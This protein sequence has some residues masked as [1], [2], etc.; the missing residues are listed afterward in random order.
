MF[1]RIMSWLPDKV[2]TPIYSFKA[3]AEYVLKEASLTV[4]SSPSMMSM[5]VERWGAK[6]NPHKASRQRVEEN[7]L[8]LMI[9]E[10]RVYS[11]LVVKRRIVEFLREFEGQKETMS[12]QAVLE[13]VRNHRQ[14]LRDMYKV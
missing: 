6:L 14:R 10:T 11:D 5:W 2:S 4:T 3:N 13:L 7:Q 12:V 8:R 9:V 1:N